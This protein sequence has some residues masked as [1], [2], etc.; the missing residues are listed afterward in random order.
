MPGQVMSG[1]SKEGTVAYHIDVQ[2]VSLGWNVLIHKGPNT[3]APCIMKLTKKKA[4]WDKNAQ[5]VITVR[6]LGNPLAA[7]D[8]YYNQ[9][10]KICNEH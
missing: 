6:L 1:F 10:M 8:Q 2:K 7:I 5:M 3:E 9:P 4:I